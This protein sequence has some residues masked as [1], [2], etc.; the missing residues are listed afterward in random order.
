MIRIF[1]YL[2]KLMAHLWKRKNPRSKEECNSGE[3][4]IIDHNYGYEV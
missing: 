4:E 2:Q 3:R 1:R